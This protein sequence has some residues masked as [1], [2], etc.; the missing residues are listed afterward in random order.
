[1]PSR[2]LLA[3]LLLGAFTPLALS[4]T[5]A[6][7][8]LNDLT[9]ANSGAVTGF[10]FAGPESL[11]W[12]FTPP[13]NI[14]I[15]SAQ[16]YTRNQF[17][18]RDMV[19]EIWSDN[20]NLPLARLG[21]GAWKILTTAPADW[22]GTNFDAAVPLGQGLSYWLVWIEPGTSLIPVEPGG[23]SRPSAR[24]SGGGAWLQRTADAPKFRLFCNQLD[25]M[26][27]T[28]SGPS[29]S[30]PVGLAVAHTNQ[31]PTVGNANF[32]LD[33]C[34]LRPA[35]PALM[36]V[37]FQN[38]WSPVPLPGGP[39]GAF[40]NVDPFM[41]VTGTTGS[42]NVR[43]TTGSNGHVFFPLP[44]PGVPQLVG[45]YVGLQV[46]ALDSSFA[47]PLPF[48]TTNGLRLTIY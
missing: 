6:C 42:G 36:L 8:S 11:A 41:L 26:N 14:V 4:Q 22:H 17:L 43:S 5:P 19:L 44:I 45:L 46:A 20:N 13:Q 12:Q 40:F 1:M 38:G 47:V 34:G 16:I 15:E 48:V 32:L 9:T 35:T 21:G 2:S 25:A 10:A 3:A 33:A 27:V 31:A 23:N 29:C 37:G 24:Q 7:V 28:P 39:P 18:A 30:S